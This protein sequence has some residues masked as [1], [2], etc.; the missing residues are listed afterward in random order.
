MFFIP[1][2]MLDMKSVFEAK[3][4]H[5]GIAIRK[6][7]IVEFLVSKLPGVRHHGEQKTPGDPHSPEKGSC[8]TFRGVKN[9]FT[10][11]ITDFKTCNLALE[12]GR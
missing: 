1:L 2:K 7:V 5:A 3:N 4:G 9:A 8:C 6:S 12:V 11:G 10:D